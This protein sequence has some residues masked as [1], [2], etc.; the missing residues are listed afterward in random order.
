MTRSIEGLVGFKFRAPGGES[1]GTLGSPVVLLFRVT[2]SLSRG[3]HARSPMISFSPQPWVP[4]H[5]SS[6]TSPPPPTPRLCLLYL[7]N[8]YPFLSGCAPFSL[9]TP[10]LPND[11]K[12]LIETNV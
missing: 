9:M 1:D 4:T 6:L 11:R 10:W 2:P 7:F 5:L 8:S 3:P 12:E